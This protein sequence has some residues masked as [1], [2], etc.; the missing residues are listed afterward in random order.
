MTDY[1]DPSETRDPALRER[2]LFARL[3]GIVAH[4]KT[5]P[6]WAR[7]LEGVDPKAV[8]SRAALAELPL[9]RK[10]DLLARQKE[11]PPFGGFNTIA[12]G[13][14]KRLH[15][16]PGPIFEPR[17]HDEN[18]SDTARALFAAGF[19]PGD[20]VHNSFSHHLTPGAYILEDGAHRLG[21]ATVPGGVGNTEQQLEAIEQFRPSGYIGT[22]D[23]VK[24]LL[25]MAEKTG[26]D[27]SSLKRGVVS[28]AAMP[29]SLHAELADR[30]FDAKQCYAIA[31]VGV[32]SYESEAAEGMIVSENMILEIVRPGSGEPVAD[33]EA[34]EVVVTS[35][36]TG[37][38][39]IRLATGD[40]SAVLPGRS[41][42]GRT[43]MRIKGWLGR[44][45]QTTKVKGMFVRPEQI[46]EIAKR[47]PELKRLRL[48]VTREGE[49]DAMTLH[50]ESE[51]SDVA[52]Q[53]A[54]A[55]TLQAMTKVRGKVELSRP[56]SLPNDGKL[57]VDERGTK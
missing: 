37:Y 32:I 57:I 22:A 19:R 48:V 6:G 15:M 4:A 27:A 50:A 47:H 26:K 10:S 5:A 39:M 23:F 53:D 49:Q 24:I 28:G 46:A 36:N 56:G 16:S 43:N 1:Y 18:F 38:P 31:E 34:G 25:D 13:T 54:I 2:E 45:D 33:G 29:A 14:A 3:P 11:T 40:L 41:P 9:L 8:T 44:A 17:C 35:F 52:F 7:Q 30:G 20:I 21:C 42:C 55:A 51:R 12:P